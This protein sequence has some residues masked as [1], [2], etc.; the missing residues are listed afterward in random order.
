MDVHQAIHERRSIRF[1]QDKEIPDEIITKILEAGHAAPSAKNSQPWHFVVIKD[2]NLIHKIVTAETPERPEGKNML[3]Y[4]DECANI[5]KV[6]IAIFFEKAKSIFVDERY[7]GNKVK[8]YFHN[9]DGFSYGD[10]LGIG[11]LLQNMSLAA[12]SLGVGSYITADLLET[13]I[14]PEIYEWLNVDKD[15]YKLISG[16][17]FGYPRGFPIK[18]KKN[19]ITDHMKVV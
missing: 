3:S 12:H 11:C 13:G 2:K 5:P 15:K 18:I 9:V 16:I 4:T 6:I 1:Y 14:N 10:L 19:P 17:R 7:F 8:P